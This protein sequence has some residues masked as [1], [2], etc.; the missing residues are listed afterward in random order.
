MQWLWDVTLWIGISN[1]VWS[2]KK[3][4]LTKREGL[5]PIHVHITQVIDQ[6]MS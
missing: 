2:S 1:F 5:D 3:P 4:S 6:Y